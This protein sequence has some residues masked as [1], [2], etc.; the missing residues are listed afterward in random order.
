[1]YALLH[2]TKDVFSRIIVETR[3]MLQIEALNVNGRT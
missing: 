1:M 3:I 2:Q